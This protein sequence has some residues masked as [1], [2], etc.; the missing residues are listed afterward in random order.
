MRRTCAAIAVAI[1][2]MGGA[3]VP[4]H[5]GAERP[6]PPQHDVFYEPPRG[7]ADKEPGAILRSRRV[8][9]ASFGE[10]P[11]EVAAW[12]LLYRT[13]GAQGRPT[14]TVT[15]VI[16]PSNGRVRG[17]VSYQ[18]A[19]DA[20]GP[21][22]APSYALRH[23]GG[24]PVG[25][26][27]SQIEILMIAAALSRGHAVSVPDWE[28][29]PGAL[30]APRQAGYQALDGVRAAEGFDRLGLR[31]RRTRVVAWGYSGGG[32]ATSWTAQ[33][34]P[35]YAPDLKLVG[36]AVGAPITAVRKTFSAINGGPFSGFYPSILPGMLRANPALR[37]AFDRHL[38]PAGKQLVEDG[39]DHCLGMH[40]VL[41]AGLDMDDYLDVPFRTLMSRPTVR[42]AFRLMNPGG[43][44]R[45]PM[46]VY[47]AVHDELVLATDT[48]VAVDRWCRKG[49]RVHYLRDRLSEHGSLMITGGPVAL[50]W[51]E[52]RLQGKPVAARCRTTTVPSTTL[53]GP[54]LTALPGYVLAGL[55]ALLSLPPEQLGVV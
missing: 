48:A 30:F 54:G 3:A 19:E 36:A 51:L 53:T 9:L 13:T 8:E 29:R 40:L 1:L 2:A 20:S 21:Q 12:Q 38:T 37:D 50:E 42:R 17:L 39:D 28:G 26:L 31:G 23:G 25:S 44:P 41:H 27:M 46:L 47:Q 32:F 33:L 22:C 24:E 6:L 34:Q 16:R 18:I 11:L 55:T 45:A 43:R 15:T 14:T 10:L 5:V 7:W 4:R 35:R 49:V 52:G